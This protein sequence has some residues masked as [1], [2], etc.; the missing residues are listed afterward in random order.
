MDESY[1]SLQLYEKLT[2]NIY[3]HFQTQFVFQE[4]GA[5]QELGSVSDSINTTAEIKNNLH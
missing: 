5:D 3:I 1:V 4:I 2:T